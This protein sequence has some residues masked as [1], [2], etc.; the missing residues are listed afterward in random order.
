M[1]DS[2]INVVW[3]QHLTRISEGWGHSELILQ[4]VESWR[5]TGRLNC[6]EVPQN[7]FINPLKHGTQYTITKII[8]IVLSNKH[9]DKNAWLILVV[10]EVYEAYMGMLG[11]S[12]GWRDDSYILCPS[13]LQVK[14][15]ILLQVA[16][17]LQTIIF[18]RIQ[19]FSDSVRCLGRVL[20][21]KRG[22]VR[23]IVLVCL[24]GWC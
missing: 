5:L 20:I 13:R 11:E 18:V 9:S 7:S 15:I 17:F 23:G 3:L 21:S 14:S 2:W 16:S 1:K 19:S 4:I 10:W 8:S 6:P 24:G 22:M 12:V